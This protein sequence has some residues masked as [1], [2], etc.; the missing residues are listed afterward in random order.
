MKFQVPMCN[1]QTITN[2]QISR[3]GI[4]FKQLDLKWIGILKHWNVAFCLLFV[5]WLLRF[6]LTSHHYTLNNHLFTN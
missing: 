5:N 2:D 3:Q 4:I 6:Q 1:F